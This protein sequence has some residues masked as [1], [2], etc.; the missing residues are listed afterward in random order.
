MKTLKST[1]T[2]NGIECF[3]NFGG[4]NFLKATAFVIFRTSITV[5]CEIHQ[6]FKGHFLNEL[7]VSFK[8]SRFVMTLAILCNNSKFVSKF[9][10]NLLVKTLFDVVACKKWNEAERSN[11]KKMELMAIQWF[12]I[13][14]IFT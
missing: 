9:I 2:K 1:V 7:R 12:E 8:L 5:S 11:S 6:K 3:N 13:A 14:L 10:V 4:E